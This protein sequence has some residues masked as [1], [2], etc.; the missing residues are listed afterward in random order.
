[1]NFYDMMFGRDCKKQETCSTATVEDETPRVRT[2][3]NYWTWIFDKDDITSPVNE[4][5]AEHRKHCKAKPGNCPFE[6]KIEN[7]GNEASKPKV[8]NE[9]MLSVGSTGN[10][11]DGNE[12]KASRKKKMLD[13]INRWGV[14]KSAKEA[15]DKINKFIRDNNLSLKLIEMKQK[16]A[17]E[18]KK[19]YDAVAEITDK[20]TTATEMYQKL[21]GLGVLSFVRN[22]S[23]RV[24]VPMAGEELLTKEYGL[25]GDFDNDEKRTGQFEKKNWELTEKSQ[26]DKSALQKFARRSEADKLVLNS[27]IND[28]GGGKI[29]LWKALIRAHEEGWVIGDLSKS[30]VLFDPNSPGDYL[31]VPTGST[32]Y[33]NA[34]GIGR[35]GI[36]S[37]V[38][39]KATKAKKE[40]EG[41]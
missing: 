23:N 1:M 35:E 5:I 20:Q 38:I 16:M 18:K 26:E 24:T 17:V 34:I 8:Q 36:I 2:S 39:L 22:P 9:E 33:A 4:T 6:K 3:T 13:S 31:V 41:R 27:K 19:F 37:Q 21:K 32:E 28:F 15:E 10:E 30:E 29:P 12:E 11:K 14:S 7:G 25:Q 40:F